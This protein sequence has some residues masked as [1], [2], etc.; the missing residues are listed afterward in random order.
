MNYPDKTHPASGQNT[1]I[2]G[3]NIHYSNKTHLSSGQ[4]TSIIRTK[5]IHYR[6]KTSII[7]INH[8]HYPE[9]TNTATKLADTIII[10]WINN[11][12][13]CIYMCV[14]VCAC[15]YSLWIN[16]QRLM[17]VISNV[18][19]S[20]TISYVYL[21][22]TVLLLLI[23]FYESLILLFM[24][25]IFT[26]FH[27]YYRDYKCNRDICLKIIEIY[28]GRSRIRP[29]DKMTYCSIPAENRCCNV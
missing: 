28:F 22:S 20:A 29:L 24:H 26:F 2:I 8:I 9:K 10:T 23:K 1:F 4:N 3:K 25:V 18:M 14:C 19:T 16:L 27:R 6:D 15:V 11:W 21:I 5:H 12:Y 7:R 13:I 17:S